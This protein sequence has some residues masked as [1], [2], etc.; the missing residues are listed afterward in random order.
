MKEK[1]FTLVELLAVLVILAII[2]VLVFP[3]VSN[4]LSQ[5]KDTIYQSQ[6]N[7]ILSATYDFSLKNINYL[8]EYNKKRYIT[9]GELKYEG[10]IDVDIKDPNTNENFPDNLVVSI[11]NVGAN[12]QY[13]DK[14]AKLKG[15]YLYKVEIEQLN[16]SSIKNLLPTIALENLVQNSD[17]NYIKILDLNDEIIDVNYVATSYDGKDITNK[18][19][20]YIL[21]ND[22]TVNNID[23]S[24]P[25]IYK[26]KY[27][28]VDD[29]GYAN[30]STLNIIIADSIPPNITLP[31]N[32]K[33]SKDI[34][35][36]DLMLGVTC[37][38]NSNYCDITTTG[39]IDYGVVGKHVITYTAK[40]PSGNTTTKERIITIE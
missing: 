27:S 38:D 10:I 12:Y 33:I 20:K 2:F 13:S 4:I 36:F 28:V 14:N 11:S 7:N 15:N 19:K 25:N 40:D 9:L 18:V 26:I 34:T 5:S 22:I 29:N 21:M 39:E 31:N 37:E 17:G 8:P 1:G 24:S 6:I 30:T 3:S 35:T 16:D 23:T 32:N